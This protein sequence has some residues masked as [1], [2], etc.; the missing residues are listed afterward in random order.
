V[1]HIFPRNYLKGKGMSRGR[2]NQVANYVITQSEINIAIGDKAPSAYFGHLVEQ[3]EGGKKRYGGIDSRAQLETN[4]AMNCI[5]AGIFDGLTGDYDR[6]LSERRH[7]MAAR[8]REYF[9]RL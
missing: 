6:F 4:L 2:Y 3:C 5:P 8:V 9:Q 7:M 1:H